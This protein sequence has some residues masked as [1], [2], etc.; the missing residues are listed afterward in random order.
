MIADVAFTF[1]FTLSELM[2]LE[3]NEL[4]TWHAQIERISKALNKR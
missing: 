2:N 4:L 1:H 3:V